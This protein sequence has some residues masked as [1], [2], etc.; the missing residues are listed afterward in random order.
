[1]SS[2]LPWLRH[3]WPTLVNAV[4]A[5]VIV[6]SVR[7]RGVGWD[8]DASAEM[9]R[10]AK[11]VFINETVPLDGYD[12]ENCDMTNVT[13]WYDG[14]TPISFNHNTIRGILHLRSDSPAIGNMLIILKAADLL[15][16]NVQLN[17]PPNVRTDVPHETLR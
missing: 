16:D 5:I 3:Y 6:V 1:M 15:A 13:L 7:F 10:P 9:K 12:Y 17:L 14:R 2:R 8:Y 11:E 4:L